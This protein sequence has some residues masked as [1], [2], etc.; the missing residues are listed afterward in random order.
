ML[1]NLRGVVFPVLL[2]AICLPA[3]CWGQRGGGEGGAYRRFTDTRGRTIHARVLQV[4]GQGVTIERRDGQQFTVP[5]ATFSPADQRFLRGLGKPAAAG[6]GRDWPRFRGPGGMGVSDATGLPVEWDQDKGIVW[7]T[8][9]PGAGASS[10]IVF[11]DRVYLTCYTGYFVPGEPGG[12]LNQLKRH[13]LAVSLDDGRILWDTAVPAK[14]PE[15]ERIRDHGFAANSVAVDA[16]RVYA[17][18]GKTGVFA[19]N[20]N[21]KQLWQT[22]AGSK[23][24]GWGTSAS[25]VLHKNLV[26]VNA[27][28]ESDSLLALDRKTGK[29]KWRAGGIRESWNTP[30]VVAAA[31]GREELVVATRGAVLAFDPDSGR[32]LWS[33][34][35]DIGWYMVPSVVAADGVIYCLGGRSGTAALAIRAGGNGDVTDTHRLWTSQK[36]SNVSSPVYH[37]GHLY[38]SHESRE[39]AYCVKA[40]TGEVVYEQRLNRAGQFYASALLADGRL[41]YLTRQGKTFVLAAR[42]QFEQLALND[43]SDG[44]VFNASPAVAGNRLLIRSDK[45]L[46]CLGK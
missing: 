46:Y 38:W 36:G 20:H 40:A 8:P 37:D 12:S 10:P 45:Y 6:Q 26:I 23:T 42:P 4:D 3:A 21:G 7:K 18:F 30:L 5:I 33:C 34:Q 43:L 11:G 17:F 2:L 14:L 27:S 15:E 39:I 28:I 44:S 19:F 24:N 35:T 13:L 25:P 22:D 41:Y 29:G 31:S 1:R 9:L 16:D 32:P